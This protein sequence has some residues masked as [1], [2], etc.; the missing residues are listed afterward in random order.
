MKTLVFYL[1]DFR[2]IFTRVMHRNNYQSV[3]RIK[4]EFEI[5]FVLRMRHLF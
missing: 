4:I 5:I 1:I 2:T 3:R